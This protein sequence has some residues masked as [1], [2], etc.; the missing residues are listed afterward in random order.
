MKR[1]V[2]PAVLVALVAVV[3]VGGIGNADAYGQGT[4]TL[5]QQWNDAEAAGVPRARI[6]PLREQLKSTESQRGGAVIYATTSMALVRNP[7][8]DLQ[9]QTQRIYDQATE[10]SR[11]QAE[12]ALAQLKQEHG[13]T[14]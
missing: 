2:A 7:L 4:R 10:E 13:P 1:I 6:D 3:A 9:R 8:Q 11:T 12:T 5:Q 14:P